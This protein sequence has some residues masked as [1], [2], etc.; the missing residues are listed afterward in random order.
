MHLLVKT[1]I[2]SKLTAGS[3]GGSSK[4]WQLTNP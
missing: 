1:K 2:E 3:S 4:A